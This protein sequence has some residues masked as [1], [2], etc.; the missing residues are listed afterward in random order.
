MDRPHKIHILKKGHNRLHSLKVLRRNGV[1]PKALRL[2]FNS[3]ILPILEYASFIFIDLSQAEGVEITKFVKRC[4]LTINDDLLSDVN[5]FSWLHARRE[6]GLKAFMTKVYSQK[7][8]PLRNFIKP[9]KSRR[10]CKP[11]AILPSLKLERTRNSF[12]IA[13]LK[14]LW[15][16]IIYDTVIYY[17]YIYYYYK[18]AGWWA[19][20]IVLQHNGLVFW[21]LVV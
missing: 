2:I 15:H 10:S 21:Q 8:H 4:N 12:F 16:F 7:Q 17:K 18:K 14:L 13:S 1:D 20:I 3:M 11:L 19:G 5:I 6:E 9:V